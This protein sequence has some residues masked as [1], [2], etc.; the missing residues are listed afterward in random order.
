M[1]IEEMKKR[2]QTLG[3]TYEKIAELAGL[4][5]GTVQKVLGGVTKSPRYDTL[6]ALERVLGEPKYADH[7]A[8]AAF[9]YH[10][11]NRREGFTL[12]DY[13]ALPREQRAEL[14]DGVF[15]DM[16][17]PSH[18]HQLISG[19][20]FR[21]LSDYIRS[22][23]GACIP[24][25]APLDVQL[26]CDDR[27]IVQPDVMV[28]CD[29]TKFQHGLVYG[30]PDFIVE[31]LSRSTRKKDSYL[32][33]AKYAAAG[34]REYWMVD[35]ERSSV[36]VYYL[37]QDEWPRIYGFQDKIPVKIFEEKCVV[38]FAAISEYISFLYDAL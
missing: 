14:I 13:Y 1:T 9:D 35:V 30:A 37:E 15:Y 12:T 26:D 18:I 38:D 7:I 22:S 27:T 17:S 31:I 34:V 8:E 16:A 10:V 36:L 6:E 32:K 21:S 33:L 4:P 3:Y 2:K 25:Y 19:E 24:A 29:R 11:K 28:V 23:R 5:L 20:I